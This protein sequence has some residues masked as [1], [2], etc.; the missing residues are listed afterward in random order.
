MSRLK[1]LLR[2]INYLSKHSLWDKREEDIVYLTNKILDDA[3]Y[4]YDLIKDKRLKILNTD[5]S[6]E[7]LEAETKSFVRIG[8]GELRLINGESQ[9]FQEYDKEIADRFIEILSKKRQDMLVGI[10]YPYF[11]ASKSDY[12]RRFSYDYRMQLLNLCDCENVY[13]NASATNLDAVSGVSKEKTDMC[14]ARWKEIFKHKNL[15]IVC[16][17]GLLDEYEHDIFE[18][19]ASKKVIHAPRRHAWREHE[20]IIAD[21]KNTAS[22]NDIVCFILGMG[23]KAMIPELTDMGY[24]C[25][26]I[27]HMAKYYNAYM[28]GMEWT[29][30]N[31]DKFYAPD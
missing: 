3:G 29:K 22:K 27:G 12:D 6:L 18:T 9:P 13:I 16:G 24:I 11:A 2:N 14:I 20:R 30:E 1:N 5:E 25:W 10:N 8:D 4:E 7:L 31:S 17:E 19:A 23:G 26:D 15:V 28:T 21:I